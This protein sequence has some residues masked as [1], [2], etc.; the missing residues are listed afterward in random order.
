MKII[1]NERSTGMGATRFTAVLRNGKWVSVS[2]HPDACYHG[3]EN[4]VHKYSVDVPECP[5]AKFYRSNSGKESVSI[6]DP[7]A[8]NLDFASF[9][10]AHRWGASKREELGEDDVM[11][12]M[13]TLTPRAAR[14]L[15][16]AA[17][18]HPRS[19]L[20][21]EI[22]VGLW[23]IVKEAIPGEDW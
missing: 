18:N 2:G 14:E 20:T 12:G 11:P 4:G 21:T 10:D 6:S 16:S 15:I 3:R 8:G 22:V 5:V 13:K 9:E 1:S 19:P 7:E 23:E 17:I